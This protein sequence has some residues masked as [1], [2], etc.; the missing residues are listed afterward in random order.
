MVNMQVMSSSTAT[1]RFLQT[2]QMTLMKQM[3]SNSEWKG[4]YSAPSNSQILFH[5]EYTASYIAA[6]NAVVGHNNRKKGPAS[7]MVN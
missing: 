5:L 6:G 2:A 3:W 1:I 4:I 7:V